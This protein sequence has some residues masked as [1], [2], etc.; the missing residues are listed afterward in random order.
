MIFLLAAEFHDIAPPVDYSLIPRWLIFVGTAV[1]LLLVGWIV[2]LIRNRKRAPQPVETPRSR[3]LRLLD[4][5]EAEIDRLKPYEFSIRVSD[6][7]RQ[8]VTEQYHLPLTRQTSVEFLNA[9]SR[10]S[11]FSEEDKML[12]DDFLNRCDLIK[13]A[14]YDATQADSRS[15]LEE[16]MRFVRGGALEPA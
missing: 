9:L 13:F 7:L 14:R 6:I 10:S 12:L 15:L 3:A 8:Y 16:A 2:W 4:D 11:E 1:A 5:A